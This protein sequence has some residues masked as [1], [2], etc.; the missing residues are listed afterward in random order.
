[1]NK[2]IIVTGG[3]KGIGNAICSH[4]L[5]N[6]FI[7]YSISR[8]TN[9]RLIN[10]RFKQ[11]RFDFLKSNSAELEEMFLNIL[12]RNKNVDEIYLFNNAGTLG[13][14][15]EVG[16]F[17]YD[18]IEKVIKVN[19]LIPFFLTNLFVNVTQ[20][21]TCSKRVINISSGAAVNPIEGWSIY[22]SSK[23]AIDMFTK[24]MGLEQEYQDTPVIVI[25]IYPGKVNTQMQEEIRSTSPDNFKRVNQFIEFKN[26]GVLYSPEFVADKIFNLLDKDELKNG[27]I[28]R[29]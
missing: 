13:E 23:S 8:S 26:S 16:G 14:V 29:L 17:S 5:N 28:I 24:V 10:N 21:W 2:V 1:M 6:G 15:K 7:V 27:E 11:V 4:Y 18:D 3:S 20:N 22:G 19:T 12:N 9:N 25:S